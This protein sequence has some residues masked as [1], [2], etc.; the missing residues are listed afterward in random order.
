MPPPVACRAFYLAGNFPH[1]SYTVHRVPADGG[2]RGKHDHGCAVVNGVGDIADIGSA[3]KGVVDH[4]FQHLSGCDNRFPRPGAFFNHLFLQ[5]GQFP[6]I[7]LH[8]QIP[9]R[10]HDGIGCTEYRMKIFYGFRI[11]DF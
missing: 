8:T 3:R 7:H 6:W 1:H 2:F 9:A 10:D 5:L 11:F 4:G